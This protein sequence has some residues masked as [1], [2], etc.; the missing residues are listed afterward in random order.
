MDWTAYRIRMP[1]IKNLLQFSFALMLAFG[2]GMAMANSAPVGTAFTVEEDIYNSEKCAS[3]GIYPPESSQGNKAGS[4][5]LCLMYLCSLEDQTLTA[6]ATVNHCQFWRRMTGKIDIGREMQ[7][8]KNYMALKELEKSKHQAIK[9]MEPAPDLGE[10][11]YSG[12]KLSVLEQTVKDDLKCNDQ[13]FTA[14]NLGIDLKSQQLEEIMTKQGC[15]GREPSVKEDFVLEHLKNF[16][17]KAEQDF[18]LCVANNFCEARDDAGNCTSSMQ[19]KLPYDLMGSSLLRYD[20]Y[21]NNMMREAARRYVENLMAASM[22]DPLDPNDVFMNLKDA[23]AG[24][25]IFKSRGAD[26]LADKYK[27]M[28]LLSLAQ[29]ALYRMYS[30]RKPSLDNIGSDNSNTFQG[31]SAGQSLVGTLAVESKRRFTDPGWYQKINTVSDTALLREL[32]NM[33]ALKNYMS[34]RLKEKLERIEAMIAVRNAYTAD[35]L[36]G[37]AEKARMSSQEA[38]GE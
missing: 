11:I 4:V 2:H 23:K 20:T 34:Y 27:G 37:D 35:K 15:Q 3:A 32:A 14:V 26:I 25:F 12:L 38:V 36:I 19:I 29:S 17:S 24:K 7:D 22:N 28:A 31:K 5:L 18:G 21:P 9:L 6:E 8:L 10:Q 13:V 33:H 1:Y 16:C 30:E